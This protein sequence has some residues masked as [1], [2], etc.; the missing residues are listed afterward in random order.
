MR[1]EKLEHVVEKNEFTSV[2]GGVSKDGEANVKIDLESIETH[3]DQ[4]NVRLRF[5]LFETYKFPDAEITAKLDKAPCGTSQPRT[6]SAYPLTLSVK[7]HGMTNQFQTVVSISARQPD[8]C[9]LRQLSRSSWPRKALGS[10]RASTLS[11][12]IGEIRIVPNAPITS[13]SV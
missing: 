6:P 12:A 13:I 7:M 5:L 11:E 2:E 1:T 10:C 9:R 4:G 8:R 3:I